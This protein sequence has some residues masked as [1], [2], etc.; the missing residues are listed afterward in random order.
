MVKTLELI[1]KKGHSDFSTDI[2]KYL[3]GRLL[4]VITWKSDLFWDS[5][6]DETVSGEAN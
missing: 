6:T 5:R 4:W 1:G 3:L 2:L